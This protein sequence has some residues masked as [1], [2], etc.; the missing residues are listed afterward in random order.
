MIFSS[1]IEEDPLRE[2]A[3]NEGPVGD[4]LELSRS[5]DQHFGM[6]PAEDIFYAPQ[7][8]VAFEK[9]SIRLEHDRNIE[10]AAAGVRPPSP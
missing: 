8:L 2:H 6:H 3:P 4:R 9:W 10:V 7:I 1:L 5:V